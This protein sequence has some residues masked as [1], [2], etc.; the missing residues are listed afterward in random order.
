MEELWTP[1]II[2][3]YGK[4]FEDEVKNKYEVSNY[5]RLRKV[6]NK[7][8]YKF[9]NEQFQFFG[10][11]MRRA[12]RIH[13][14]TLMSF[15][16]ESTPKN[17]NDYDCDHINGDHYDNRLENLQWLTRKKHRIK[18]REQ[19]RSTRKG[20]ADG[21]G[22]RVKVV[23]VKGSGDKSKLNKEFLSCYCAASNLGL[24]P[25]QISKGARNRTWV[26]GI[27]LF[28]YLTEK[29]LEGEKF[30]HLGAY[31]VSNRGRVKMKSGKITIGSK[32]SSKYRKV[33]IKI[34]DDLVPR[35]YYVHILMWIGFFGVV[36]KG[37]VVMHTDK[38]NTLDN[39]GFERNWLEDLSLGTQSENMQSYNDH[40]TDLKR[41]RCTDTGM[42]YACSSAAA[43]ALGIK[44][45]H[46]S[47][48]C[49]N[50]RRKCG[51]YSFEYIN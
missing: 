4:N 14:V 10:D 30:V 1:V 44:S 29:L 9:Q 12:L 17:V 18:T 51:G 16:P 31:Q 15:K 3:Q 37:K 8:V 2:S 24:R 40:R 27:Y 50:K 35:N 6:S 21:Q 43:R 22:K 26:C 23:C 28:E 7:K 48:V 34:F 38:Y 46:I 41:V 36:P 39:E 5:S 19:T 47:D 32:T 49:R 42:E 20:L 11:G 13:R 33:R 45:N 25:E